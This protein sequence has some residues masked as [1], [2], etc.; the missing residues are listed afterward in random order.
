MLAEPQ[1]R[2]LDGGTECTLENSNGTMQSSCAIHNASDSRVEALLDRVLR[3]ESHIESRYPA[4]MKQMPTVIPLM[5]SSQNDYNAWIAS[6]RLSSN[7]IECHSTWPKYLALAHSNPVGT[8]NSYFRWRGYP[9]CITDFSQVTAHGVGDYGVA[10][11]W[12]LCL[13][14]LL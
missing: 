10:Q 3:L 8:L 14:R 13:V 5:I 7:C 11:C 4:S 2:L 12:G 1:I 6:Q 9:C